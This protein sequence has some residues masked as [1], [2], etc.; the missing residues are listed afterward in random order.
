MIKLQNNSNKKKEKNLLNPSARS[1]LPDSP[2]LPWLALVQ[3]RTDQEK[4]HGREKKKSS[5]YS[6]IDL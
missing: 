3:A 4:L 1:H 5:E 6:L 2:P